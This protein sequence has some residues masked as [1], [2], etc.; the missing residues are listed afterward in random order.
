MIN[1]KN[2]NVVLT[3][4]T[5]G[6]GNSI[7]EVLV[8]AEA[9]IVATGTNEEKLN[10]IKNKYQT[11]KVEKFDISEHKNIENFINRVSDKLGNKIDIL[12]NNAGVTSDNLS[13]RMKEEEWKKVIDIN[14]TS[15]FLLS[16]NVLKK[17]LKEKKGKIINITSVVGHAGNVGQANYSASK[18]GLVAMSKSLALEYGKKNININCV[19]PGFISTE[20]TNKIDENYKEILKSKIPMD[21]F[22][23]PKDVANTVLFL[24]SDL[25]DYITGETIHVNGGM[26]FS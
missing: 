3:G 25:S 12:I 18:A 14:L 21:R 24:C 7:L 6:I 19:S 13:I 5:G 1:L 20:M 8:D 10:K 22:G 4:A 23:D 16:K 11:V 15:T 2:T 26:Y 9:N 17:M